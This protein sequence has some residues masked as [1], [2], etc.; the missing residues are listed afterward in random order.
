MKMGVNTI[1]LR[2]RLF[3][4]HIDINVQLGIFMTPL[5]LLGI[6]SYAVQ[7]TKTD[8]KYIYSLQS[9]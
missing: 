5:V 9:I 8:N 7:E 2:L 6:V 3:T 1:L 4:K